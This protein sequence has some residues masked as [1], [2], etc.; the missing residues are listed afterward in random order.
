MSVMSTLDRGR[1]RVVDSRP[2]THIDVPERQ[3]EWCCVL[4]PTNMLCLAQGDHS[5][6]STEANQSDWQTRT[7]GDGNHAAKRASRRYTSLP[8]RAERP[9][10]VPSVSPL[11]SNSF[12][13]EI[14]RYLCDVACPASASPRRFWHKRCISHLAKSSP[15]ERHKRG[16]HASSTSTS[17]TGAGLSTSIVSGRSFWSGIENPSASP[18]ESAAAQWTD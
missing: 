8:S 4:S 5:G 7:S 3:A 14:S 16:V 13:G 9:A 15:E 2:S 17:T 12:S 18:K 6:W 1:R 10:C 11:P